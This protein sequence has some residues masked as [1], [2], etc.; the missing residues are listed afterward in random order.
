MYELPGPQATTSGLRQSQ[1]QTELLAL[2]CLKAVRKS[3]PHLLQVLVWLAE[4]AVA[5]YLFLHFIFS[6]CLY[7][8][9]HCRDSGH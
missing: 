5:A 4:L 3:F 1:A 6:L 8:L 9:S 7:F 2:C